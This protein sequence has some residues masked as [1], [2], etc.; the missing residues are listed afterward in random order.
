MRPP[1]LASGRPQLGEKLAV[2][3]ETVG[4]PTIQQGGAYDAHF[5]L[6]VQTFQ[7]V[8]ALQTKTESER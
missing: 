6:A 8:T 7:I 3:L 4:I 5:N 1:L 2:S